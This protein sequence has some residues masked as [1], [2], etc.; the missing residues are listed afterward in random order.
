MGRMEDRIGFLS[1]DFRPTALQEDALRRAFGGSGA[2]PAAALPDELPFEIAWLAPLLHERA[3]WRAGEADARELLVSAAV[4]YERK[5][6]GARELRRRLAA[7]DIECLFFKGLPL[8][9]ATYRV[10][11]ERPMTD[12]DVLVRPR[13]FAAALAVLERG[14]CAVRPPTPDG[15]HA[16]QVAWGGI[17]FDLHWRVSGICRLDLGE[18]LWTEALPFDE[19]AGRLVAP[20]PAHHLAIVLC[21]GAFWSIN[22][23]GVWVADALALLERHAALDW[24]GVRDCALAPDVRLG[25]LRCLDYLADRFGVQESAAVRAELRAQPVPWF[26][27]LRDKAASLAPPTRTLRDRVVLRFAGVLARDRG[28]RPATP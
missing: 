21:H 13:D 10:P 11:A 1:A 9:A 26:D 19:K 16:A 3:A 20:A 25:L 22:A 15:T 28:Q 24:N 23:R 27:A 6:R 12:V 2:A 7:A 8:A 4:D 17:P 18:R 14:G 5:L